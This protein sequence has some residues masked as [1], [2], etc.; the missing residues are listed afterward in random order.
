MQL[1]Q[2]LAT[3]AKKEVLVADPFKLLEDKVQVPEE[4]QIDKQYSMEREDYPWQNSTY[5][6]HASPLS[7]LLPG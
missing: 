5:D 1:G 4:Q 7:P 3:A 2:L 6:S